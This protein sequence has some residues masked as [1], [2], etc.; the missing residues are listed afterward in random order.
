[1]RLGTILL[2]CSMLTLC[3]CNR[4][5]QHSSDE[6]Q[7]TNA[8]STNNVAVNK[9]ASPD[10]RTPLNEPKGPIDPKSVEA[11]GQ[12]VQGYG[13]L[14]EQ[15]RWTEA[16]ALWGDSALAMKFETDLAQLAD[17]HLE[18]GNLGEPE[19]AAGSIYVTMP[20]IFYGDLHNGQ[21]FRRS[22]DVTLRRVNDVPGSTDAQRRWHIERIDW[23]S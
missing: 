11:A 12:I 19:G 10:D 5:A 13:A 3:A 7:P 1:M 9:A 15:G 23:A 2:G 17:V 21:P 14:I 22:A 20:V 18:I 16:N 8:I 6:Q 4:P